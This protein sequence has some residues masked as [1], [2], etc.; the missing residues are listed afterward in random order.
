MFSHCDGL[1]VRIKKIWGKC[2]HLD[3]S[4]KHKDIMIPKSAQL[5]KWQPPVNIVSP[6]YSKLNIHSSS[7]DLK[8]GGGERKERKKKCRLCFLPLF[9][10]SVKC[11]AKKNRNC[12]AYTLT[13]SC[14]FPWALKLLRN[15]RELLLIKAC[16][17]ILHTDDS[18]KSCNLTGS[19]GFNTAH[20]IRLWSSSHVKKIKLNT[21]R[22]IKQFALFSMTHVF[23]VE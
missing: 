21:T 4:N 17:W 7:L 6:Q 19:Q 10:S 9:L 23:D 22:P 8:K 16:I 5:Q 2:K 3:C 11:Q 18:Q 15:Y 14:G 12:L 1:L 13:K 20:A